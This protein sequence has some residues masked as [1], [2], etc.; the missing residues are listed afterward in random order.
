[1]KIVVIGGTGLIGRGVVA[2]LQEQG[3]EVVAASPSTG[4]DAVTGT[5]LAAALE[6]AD[7]VVDT[8]NA[9]SFEDGPVHEFFERSTTNLVA[10]EKTAGVR[11]HVVLSIVGADRMP[12]I[13]YMRAKLTQERIVRESGVPFTILRATQFFEFI[14]ALADGATHDGTATLSDVLMQPIAA[15]DVSA[16][17]AEVAVADPSNGIV[18]LAGP[19]PLRLDDLARRLLSASGDPRTVVTDPD[20]GYFGGRVDDRSLTPGNDP[21]I[22][23]HRYGGTT[24][25]RW[26]EERR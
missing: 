10:A 21:A 3:H 23:D 11:H 19:E 6:G 17:L 22:T 20:A 12:D 16:A 9:P 2:H 15:A 8:P 18:E 5:G 14:G 25:S 26:L 24:F 13:G 4:V 7:V 1:M